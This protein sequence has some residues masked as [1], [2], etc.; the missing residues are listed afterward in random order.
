MRVLFWGSAIFCASFF[1]HLVIWKVRLPKRQSK[2]LFQIFFGVLVASISILWG[3]SAFL[4]NRESSAPGSHLEYLHI[5]LFFTSLTLAY[6]L[7]YVAVEV[8][9]PSLV[10]VMSIAMAGSEGLDEKRFN[11]RM[12]DDLLIKPRIRDLVHDELIYMEGN[13]Y[14]LTSKGFLVVRIFSLYRRLLNAEI[15]G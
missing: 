8:D 10:M 14:K 11:Q 9:S 13:K 3:T 15:G 6:I 4:A 7:T 12:T 5:C 2:A 1:L